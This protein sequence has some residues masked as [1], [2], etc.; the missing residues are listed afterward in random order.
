VET[1]FD[2]HTAA[3]GPGDD[4]QVLSALYRAARLGY[5]HHARIRGESAQRFLR[6]GEA[7]RDPDGTLPPAAHYHVQPGLSVEIGRSNPGEP[8]RIDRRNIV[9]CG[10]P[11][12]A[13][14]STEP[15][16]RAELRCVLKADVH[17]F[18]GLMR[19]GSDGPVRKALD[20]AIKKWSQGAY[21]TETRGGD[22][23]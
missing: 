23:F 12:R 6:P 3:T 16:V 22:S 2:D 4:K 19:S 1:R 5:V 17:G 13:T 14:E 7:T 9:G 21:I 8:Q 11:W 18:G 20:D 15:T 10:R